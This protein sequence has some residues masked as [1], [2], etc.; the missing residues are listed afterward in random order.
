MQGCRVDDR[1]KKKTGVNE[2]AGSLAK[3]VAPET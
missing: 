1:K 2:I 3:Q